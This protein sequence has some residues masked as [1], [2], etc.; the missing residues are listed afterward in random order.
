MQFGSTVATGGS[1]LQSLFRLR[2][3]RRKVKAVHVV[4][5]RNPV[6]VS[7]LVFQKRDAHVGDVRKD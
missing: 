5:K 4:P 3:E 6:V 7:I 2:R 1:E